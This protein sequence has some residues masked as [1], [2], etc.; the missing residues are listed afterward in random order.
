MSSKVALLVALWLLVVIFAVVNVLA[1]R[2]W[3][4]AYHLTLWR[5]LDG[6][7]LDSFL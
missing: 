4:L 7:L 1:A 2:G 5:G 6:F 3:R